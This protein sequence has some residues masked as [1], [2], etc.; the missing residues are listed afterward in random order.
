MAVV[1]ADYERCV[2]RG[3]PTKEAEGSEKTKQRRMRPRQPQH[4]QTTKVDDEWSDFAPYVEAWI[5]GPTKKE[6]QERL[7]SQNK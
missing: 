4:S 7:R 5:N 3:L 6:I 2:Q 1:I